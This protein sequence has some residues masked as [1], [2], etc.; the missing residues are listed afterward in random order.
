VFPASVETDRLRLERFDGLDPTTLYERF[1]P[2]VAP[3]V[4]SH[5][6]QSP[7]ETLMD[8]REALVEAGR[9]FEEGEAAR[10]AVVP[11]PDEPTPA[12][13]DPEPEG[14][15]GNGPAAIGYAEL[16]PDWERR[17]GHVGVLLDRPY[18]GREYAG[19]CAGAL[20]RTGIERLDLELVAIG[21]EAGNERSRGFVEKWAERF[22]GQRDGVLRNWTR[23]DGELRDHHR[24]TVTAA[25]YCRA[26]DDD[27]GSGG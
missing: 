3:A 22:D 7:Y 24:Y 27:P 9:R 17:T 18:W 25:E 23:V 11:D 12:A 1:G 13:D 5:V 14:E 10:Y 8:A 15:N 2:G 26:V 21:F 16:R 4:F 6:P 19:E 20:T